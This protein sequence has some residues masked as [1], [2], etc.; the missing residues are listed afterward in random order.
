MDRCGRRRPFCQPKFILLHVLLFSLSWGWKGGGEGSC[1]VL[2]VVPIPVPVA[3]PV[4]V[5]A[6]VPIIVP[7]TT[8][9]RICFMAPHLVTNGTMSLVVFRVFGSFV[10]S[11]TLQY[12]VDRFEGVQLCRC[13]HFAVALQWRRVCHPT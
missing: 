6:T 8:G 1:V 13:D 12:L 10:P 2:V 4:A 9:I 3:V 7:T 5:P 11:S